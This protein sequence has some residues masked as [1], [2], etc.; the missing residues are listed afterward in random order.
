MITEVREYHTV[1]PDPIGQL[2]DRPD[3]VPSG[4]LSRVSSSS[5]AKPT[6]NLRNR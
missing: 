2:A 5:V 6:E 1:V 4:D 3:S